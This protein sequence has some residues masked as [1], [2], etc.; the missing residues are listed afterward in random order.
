MDAE[1]IHAEVLDKYARH[2]NP[3]LARLMNF[4]GFPV[5]APAEGG[6]PL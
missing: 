1:Q 3:Y 6:A 4:A 5:E 2:V